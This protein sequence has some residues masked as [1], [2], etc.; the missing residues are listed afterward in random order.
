M[1]VLVVPLGF[2]SATG[3][4]FSAQDVVRGLAC[5][6][7]CPECGLPLAAKKGDVL[8]WHFA[9]ASVFGGCSGAAESSL[10]KLAKQVLAE[11]K[12]FLIPGSR[13][14]PPAY[15]M[16]DDV[17]VERQGGSVRPDLIALV[18]K[19]R[20]FVEVCVTHGVDQEK[21][22]KICA[23]GESCVEYWAPR[24]WA[25]WLDRGTPF[26]GFRALMLG[27]PARWVYHSREARSRWMETSRF[28]NIRPL[29]PIPPAW[30]PYVSPDKDLQAPPCGD[31]KPV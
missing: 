3:K 9:H 22:D 15:V 17:L 18:G 21:A 1:T 6:C 10:H 8:T 31:A 12:L 13:H 19:R 29:P 4:M 2:D 30:R 14:G 7:V 26:W 24:E 23:M 27:A 16:A 5:G 20:L 11:E 25:S 28:A